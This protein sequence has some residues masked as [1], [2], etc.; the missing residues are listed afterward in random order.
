MLIEIGWNYCRFRFIA[1]E[2]IASRQITGVIYV[3]VLSYRVTWMVFKLKKIFDFFFWLLRPCWNLSLAWFNSNCWLD[4]WYD[5]Y[6]KHFFIVRFMHQLLGLCTEQLYNSKGTQMFSKLVEGHMD[7]K[8]G[9]SWDKWCQLWKFSNI[10]E[11]VAT[12]ILAR[13]NLKGNYVFCYVYSNLRY[14]SHLT[15]LA[16]CGDDF[17]FFWRDFIHI[18]KFL[19]SEYVQQ[20]QYQFM[21]L[22]TVLYARKSFLCLSLNTQTHNSAP[23]RWKKKGFTHTLSSDY[24]SHFF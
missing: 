22:V 4:V 8:M 15:D 1:S 17:I 24:F 7:T 10:L 23:L 19:V 11:S 2:L 13:L 20:E 16:I 9:F 14:A 21:N 12:N 18:L 5:K 6:A 3:Y